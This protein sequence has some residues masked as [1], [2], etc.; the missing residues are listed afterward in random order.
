MN[1]PI[2]TTVVTILISLII[3]V[4]LLHLSHFDERSQQSLSY[5][6]KNWKWSKP[7]RDSQRFRCTI[8][9][10]DQGGRLGNRLFMFASATGLALTH[11][12]YLHISAEII[13]ELNQSFELDLARLP[14]GFGPNRSESER[15]IS[16]HCSYL[17]DLFSANTSQIIELRGF[18]QVHTY[19]SNYSTEIRR[20]LRLKPLILLKVNAFLQNNKSR[21]TLVGIHIR[22]GDFLG[23]RAVSSDQYVFAAMSYFTRKYSSVI[24]VIVTDDRSYCARVFG[25]RKDVLFTPT[26]FN[27]VMNLPLSVAV[28]MQSSLWAPSGGGV[29]TFF[30]IEHAR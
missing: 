2:H 28:I 25:K 27:S 21:V 26:S 30:M 10:R 13:H 9:L 29:P 3:I 12:C 11:S 7:T 1:C 15:R 22:R 8:I 19:F 23:L 6:M 4:V 20:Q 16:N 18:W 5:P 24:F 14:A 17:T